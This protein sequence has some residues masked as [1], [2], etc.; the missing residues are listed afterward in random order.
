MKSRE[1]LLENKL[2]YDYVMRNYKKK[3][4]TKEEI[5]DYLIEQCF[6]S[7]Q[8]IDELK[9][10]LNSIKKIVAIEDESNYKFDSI[11]EDDLPF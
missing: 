9:E 5:I 2:M 10:R 8:Y 11:D 7:E 6:Y 4:K 1:E 3:K